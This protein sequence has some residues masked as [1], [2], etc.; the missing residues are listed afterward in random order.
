MQGRRNPLTD[1]LTA[2]AKAELAAMFADLKIRFERRYARIPGHGRRQG[3]P[4]WVTG[5]DRPHL[6]GRW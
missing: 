6:L 1:E 4:A 2:E 5:G 3:L